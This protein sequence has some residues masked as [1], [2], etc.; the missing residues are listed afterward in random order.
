MS[1]LYPKFKTED[2]PYGVP[3]D[4]RAISEEIDVSEE[5]AI[6]L[7]LSRSIKDVLPAY[8]M[9]DGPL[10]M[11]DLEHIRKLA[12][13]EIANKGKLRRSRFLL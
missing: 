1:N 5:M 9:D 3:S 4:T 8:E 2:T 7:V 10:S 13:P 12:Q 11:R 6:Q